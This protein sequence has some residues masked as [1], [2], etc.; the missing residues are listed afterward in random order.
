MIYRLKFID[1]RTS[2]KKLRRYVCTLE[3]F[4]RS[5]PQRS[6]LSRISVSKSPSTTATT[7][8]LPIE[9][10]PVMENRFTP[11]SSRRSSSYSNL[12]NLPEENPS[13]I[14]T[15]VLESS[16]NGLSNETY[17]TMEESPMDCSN[18]TT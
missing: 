5:L 7:S 2:L 10:L 4:A 16:V 17:Q 1:L 14:P 18:A 6:F 11:V 3:D 12:S 9:S 13:L 15:A 8:F